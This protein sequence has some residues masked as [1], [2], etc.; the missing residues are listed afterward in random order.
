MTEGNAQ[1]VV[2]KEAGNKVYMGS[3][4]VGK[5]H[6]Q[7]AECTHPLPGLGLG[8]NLHCL[9]FIF[10]WTFPRGQ[11]WADPVSV[12]GKKEKKKKAAPLPIKFESASDAFHLDEGGGTCGPESLSQ[13][14]KP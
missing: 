5:P 1:G 13:A 6:T 7:G 8:L 10:S 12:T 9:F 2:G 4:S 3:N 14:E 11:N